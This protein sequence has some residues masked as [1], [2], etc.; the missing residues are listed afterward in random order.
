MENILFAFG[1]VIFIGYF[2]YQATKIGLIDDAIKYVK[3][4]IFKIPR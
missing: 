2:T 3:H 1:M 4:E